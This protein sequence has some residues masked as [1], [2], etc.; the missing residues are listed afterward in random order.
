S[1]HPRLGAD[2]RAGR[3]VAWPGRRWASG[4]PEFPQCSSAIHGPR[5][6]SGRP[7]TTLERAGRPAGAVP[8]RAAPARS[9][10]VVEAAALRAD[11]RRRA[12]SAG[13]DGAGES[14]ITAAILFH[15][16]A[17]IARQCNYYLIDLKIELSPD[18]PS[19][20]VAALLV[21]D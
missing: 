12:G 3:A 20:V 9:A 4:S 16:R 13:E 21:R 14:V 2:S 17:A 15:V 10:G 18:A 11:L 5:G 6:Q 1:G 8:G 19:Q 7:A